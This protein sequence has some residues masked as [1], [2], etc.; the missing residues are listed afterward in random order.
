MKKGADM[1]NLWMVRRYVQNPLATFIPS[2]RG[3]QGVGRRGAE[4]T[5]FGRMVQ[6]NVTRGSLARAQPTALD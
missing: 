5:P 4:G 1:Q 3:C 2:I 6:Y